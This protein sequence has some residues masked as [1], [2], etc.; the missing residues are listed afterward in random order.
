VR[1]ATPWIANALGFV[2]AVGCQKASA[3]AE[4]P[5][6]EPSA[7]AKPG[8]G[9]DVAVHRPDLEGDDRIEVSAER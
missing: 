1:T 6:E 2:L 8:G 4:A 5:G 9:L 7:P 3:P